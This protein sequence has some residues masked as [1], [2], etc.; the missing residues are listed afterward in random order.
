VLIDPAVLATLP[1]RAYRAGLYEALKCGVI[2]D[3]AL[4]SF[5][6]QER[7]RLLQRD[8][9]ILEHLIEACVRVKAEVVAAD[10]R[11]SGLRRILNFGHTI[12]H[13]LEAESGYRR[14]LHGE[15]VAWGM[16]A[17]ALLAVETGRAEAKT[18]Q[19]IVSLVRAYGPLPP[20]K[21]RAKSLARRLPADK[22]T[23]D[24]VVHFVL[25]DAIGRVQIA[26]DV[27]SA[28]V[29]RAIEGMQRLSQA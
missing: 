25:P 24:G 5:M 18:A 23:R 15:A 1:E 27:S 3:P 7:E 9:Q 12:G 29:V 21:A 13:A 6:E 2:C 10:E 4:F 22:K 11:E 16:V 26:S 20:V 17:A 8:P 28:A 14:F 19:R